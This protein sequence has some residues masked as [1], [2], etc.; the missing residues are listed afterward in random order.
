MAFLLD[1]FIKLI[2]PLLNFH[3]LQMYI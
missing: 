2:F 1:W 3:N